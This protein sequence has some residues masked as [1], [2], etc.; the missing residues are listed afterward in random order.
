MQSFSEA[1]VT[2]LWHHVSM[3]LHV[4]SKHTCSGESRESSSIGYN[5]IRHEVI[6]STKRAAGV[7]V[8][9]KPAYRGAANVSRLTNAALGLLCSKT[10]GTH[11]R[12]WD[13]LSEGTHSV[14]TVCRH[15]VLALGPAKLP[16]A[17]SL[18]V[19]WTVC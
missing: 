12:V 9:C 7:E 4:P 5:R 17:S 13:I 11:M 8:G 2:S 6:K 3:H 15:I 1:A 18:T 10:T 14:H 16:L 19:W